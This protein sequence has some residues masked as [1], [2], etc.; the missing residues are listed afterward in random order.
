MKTDLEESLIL[1]GIII[2][3]LFVLRIINASGWNGGY[4]SCGGKWHY[5]QA[6]GHRYDTTYLYECDKCGKTK[7]FYSKYAE[8]EE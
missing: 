4:C 8:V 6:I 7:E 5:Q 3:L 1:L 2:A